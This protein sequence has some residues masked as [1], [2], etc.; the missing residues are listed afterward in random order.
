[1]FF[2]GDGAAPFAPLFRERMGDRAVF[3]AEGEGLPS[4]AAVGL[5][6]ARLVF[7]GAAADPRQAVP[8]YV[9]PFI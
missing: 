4:A 9:R 5:L 7:S 3:A 2:C 1:V 6:A 8:A